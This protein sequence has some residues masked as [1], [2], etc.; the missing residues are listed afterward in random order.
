MSASQALEH[1]Y[2]EDLHDPEDEP[3]MDKLPS[4]FDFEF[5][6]YYLNREDLRELIY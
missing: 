6:K 1:P 5:E 3:T 2:Y 4:L